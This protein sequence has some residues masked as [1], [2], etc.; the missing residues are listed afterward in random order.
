MK[1][2]PIDRPTY[3]HDCCPR[4]D[5][6]HASKVS[7]SIFV[8]VCPFNNPEGWLHDD[9]RVLTSAK[10]RTMDNIQHQ[11]DDVSGFA[12]KMYPEEFWQ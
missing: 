9:T 6:T 10:S 5:I 7:S 1:R 12:K 11:M 2:A 8:K 4:L 3:D